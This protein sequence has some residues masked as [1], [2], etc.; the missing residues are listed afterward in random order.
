M[1]EKTKFITV[2]SGPRRAIVPWGLVTGVLALVT[3]GVAFAVAGPGGEPD[4]DASPSAGVTPSGTTGEPSVGASGTLW[5]VDGAP[6]AFAYDP[7]VWAE[8]GP[9]WS[10]QTY[11]T[12]SDDAGPV[13]FLLVSPE[14][15]AYYL[16]GSDDV[17]WS[18]L[19]ADFDRS[20]MHV[21]IE[22]AYPD[23]ESLVVV[24]D[25]SFGEYRTDVATLRLDS[26]TF[27]TPGSASL[28]SGATTARAVGRLPDGGIVWTV[29][30]VGAYYA[31]PF[32]AF[33]AYV[34]RP[35]GTWSRVPATGVS[36][37][38][39]VV[40]AD[41]GALDDGRLVILGPGVDGH[42]FVGR[43]L[44]MNTGEL[45]ASLVEIGPVND[46]QECGGIKATPTILYAGCSYPDGDAVMEWYSLV[47]GSSVDDMGGPPT[48]T[49]GVRK[50]AFAMDMGFSPGHGAAPGEDG[51]AF[52]GYG[53]DTLTGITS[54]EDFRLEYVIAGLTHVVLASDQ[55]LADDA[56]WSA[57]GDFLLNLRAE[58]YPLS[59]RMTG[60]WLR[61]LEADGSH[62]GVVVIVD[63]VSGA[64]RQVVPSVLPDGNRAR[65][66]WIDWF[67]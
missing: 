31:D 54:P 25:E 37:D 65:L 61:R 29:E 16:F 59:D 15:V 42:S 23:S 63:P 17:D 3:L 26:M 55:L 28:D 58:V 38:I 11:G 30:R 56:A 21:S 44:D 67:D 24:A 18:W 57:S 9:G 48:E 22:A 41:R 20:S 7:D 64:V 36:E 45:S 8:V 66:L 33:E 4:L 47:P 10:I 35:D 27:V 34:S 43:L 53:P 19:P 51:F 52:R 13:A 6:A 32:S 40:G 49:P 39:M 50:W 2:G 5:H 60:V 46:G 14:G 12:G 62:S 1:M